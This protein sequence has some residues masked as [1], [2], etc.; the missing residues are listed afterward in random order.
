MISG[1]DGDDLRKL[2]RADGPLLAMMDLGLRGLSDDEYLWE[3]VAECWSVR[4]RAEQSTPLNRWLPDGEAG[5]DLEYPDP[6]PPPFTTIAWRMT[7]L[8]GSTYIGASLLRGRRLDS[9]HLD[10]HWDEHLAPP[11]TADEVIAR[12]TTPSARSEP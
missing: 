7:H 4:P 3:P 8:I 5:L 6:V 2:L 12:G 10:E 11:A 9:R 1:V